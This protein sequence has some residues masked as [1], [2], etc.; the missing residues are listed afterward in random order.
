MKKILLTSLFA[1]AI[2]GVAMAQ[3]TVNW[4]SISFASFT[5]Q[6]NSTQQSAV[7]GNGASTGNGA[8]G[9][10]ASASLVS[11]NNNLFYFELLTKAQPVAGVSTPQP[12]TLSSLQTWSDAG[13]GATNAQ[14]AGRLAVTVPNAAATVGW[15]NGTTNYIMMVGWSASLGSTWAAALANLQNSSYLSGLTAPAYFG[16][17]T[18]GFINP[19]TSTT[20]GQAVFG[21]AGAGGTPII[22]LN[23]QLYLVGVTAT[24]EPGTMA[25]AALGGA[26][27]LLFR[28]RK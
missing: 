3:G 24:P 5:A 20:A 1:I 7:F 18:T 10:T 21:A 8:V 17:S 9:G 26:S 12:T 13:L 11:G 2:S 28:R 27:L 25:L 6:T 23:T 19:S 15:A 22:S 14:T 16:T 4:G